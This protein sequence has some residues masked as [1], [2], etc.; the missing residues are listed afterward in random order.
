M[1]NTWWGPGLNES[2]AGEWVEA[3]FSQPTDLL[4][5]VI[6]SGEST[7][8]NDLSK[9]AL[10]QTIEAIVTTADGQPQSRLLTLDQ[11]GGGQTRAFRFSDV[12][13]VRFVLRSAYGVSATKQVAIAE[14]EFFGPSS[15]GGS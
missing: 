12:T 14:I 7:L 5:V 11:A 9:S 15:G 6:T 4:D 10:P 2:D 8:P 1:N 3:D 13:S